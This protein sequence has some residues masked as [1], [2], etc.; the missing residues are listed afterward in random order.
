M[1]AGFYNLH[2]QMQNATR[3]RN[4]RWSSEQIQSNVMAQLLQIALVMHQNTLEVLAS[5][6]ISLMDIQLQS[7]S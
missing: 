1:L 2:H 6:P 7:W 4:C 3:N 5:I